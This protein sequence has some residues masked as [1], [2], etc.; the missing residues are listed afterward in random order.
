MDKELRDIQQKL[1]KIFIKDGYIPARE[2]GGYTEVL[3]NG[4]QARQLVNCMGHSCF[5]LTNRQLEDYDIGFARD[6]E[7]YFGKMLD[8]KRSQLQCAD[9]I[10]SFIKSVG[11]KVHDCEPEYEL[12]DW[13]S[14]KVALYFYGLEDYHFLLHERDGS[15][16]SKAGDSPTLHYYSEAPETYDNCYELFDCFSI[17]NPK[18]DINNKYVRNSSAITIIDRLKQKQ[19][20][21]DIAE[22]TDFIM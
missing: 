3:S 2:D 6:K 19:E 1:N 13:R 15:W 14:W 9:H 5:N 4:I 22:N 12:K 7:F 8:N 10:R 16:S 21:Q 11:L 20:M 17:T 18:A